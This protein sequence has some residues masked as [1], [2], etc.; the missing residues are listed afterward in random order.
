M[1]EIMV[2]HIVKVVVVCLKRRRSYALM[3]KRFRFFWNFDAILPKTNSSNPNFWLNILRI[4]KGIDLGLFCL[5]LR[6]FGK[7]YGIRSVRNWHHFLG[8]KMRQFESNSRIFP[9]VLGQ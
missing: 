5:G 7:I 6:F 3:K 9:T 2:F 1:Q 4:K 8:S